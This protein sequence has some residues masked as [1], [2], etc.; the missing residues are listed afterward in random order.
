VL[1]PTVHFVWRNGLLDCEGDFLR[2][3]PGEAAAG[4]LQT[5]VQRRQQIQTALPDMRSANERYRH[6]HAS[7]GARQGIDPHPEA[8]VKIR[9]PGICGEGPDRTGLQ[10]NPRLSD[11]GYRPRENARDRERQPEGLRAI[12]G[13]KTRSSLRR[14]PSLPQRQLSYPSGI[15]NENHPKRTAPTPAPCRPP[16]PTPESKFQRPDQTS[17][18]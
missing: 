13:G 16:H 14:K 2:L 9:G 11:G 10:P 3:R 1:G 15:S 5:D 8:E 17:S 7:Q 18:S 4:I 6:G 12:A